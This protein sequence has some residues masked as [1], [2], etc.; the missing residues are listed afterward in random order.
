VKATVVRDI[1]EKAKQL[2]FSSA[3][4]IAESVVLGV[5]RVPNQRSVDLL[6]R[7]GNRIREKCRPKHPTDLK[8][9]L[10]EEYVPPE[11]TTC[12]V[13]VGTIHK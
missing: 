3:F 13:T 4:S 12:D 8:F 10:N 5:N 11:F 1:K 2:P 6:G 7:I 9:D